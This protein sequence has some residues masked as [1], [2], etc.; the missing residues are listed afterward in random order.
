MVELPGHRLLPRIQRHDILDTKGKLLALV[1]K[2]SCGILI[3]LLGFA[4]SATAPAAAQSS[5]T[6]NPSFISIFPLAGVKSRAWWVAEYDHP[7]SKFITAWR[8]EGVSVDERGVTLSLFPTPEENIVTREKMDANRKELFENGKTW[9]PITSG[10]IQRVG[11]YGYGR[12]EIVM[13]PSDVFGLISAFYVYTGEHFGDTHEE[14]DFEFLARNP[15]QVF[16]NR[17]VDGEPLPREVHHELGFVASERPRVYAFDW[18]E[19]AVVWY[20]DGEEI[21]RVDQE[22]GIPRPPAKIYFDIWA[23]ADRDA[24]WS[25]TAAPDAEG[26]MLV[27]CVSYRK[28][29]EDEPQCSDFMID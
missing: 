24:R 19:D 10:Q 14:I 4:A 18:Q 17:W 11:W 15:D 13:Q 23:G 6:E 29:G 21:Y 16:L 22:D 25:G 3:P 12:Y 20:A 28:T 7:W 1:Q 8:D 27:Q 9:K 2:L 26:Q 5:R